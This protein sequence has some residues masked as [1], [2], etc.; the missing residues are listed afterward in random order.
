MLA[1]LLSLNGQNYKKANTSCVLYLWLRLIVVLSTIVN[2][3][4]KNLT[5]LTVTINL[6]IKI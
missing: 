5:D 6:N 2:I 4:V 3:K 1:E